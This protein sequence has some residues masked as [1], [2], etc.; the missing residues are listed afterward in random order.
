MIVGPALP[1]LA[2]LALAV[3]WLRTFC[4]AMAV[5]ALPYVVAIPES[6]MFARLVLS[7]AYWLHG[8]A[9]LHYTSDVLAAGPVDEGCAVCYAPHGLIPWGFTLNGAVR[10]KTK[11]VHSQPSSFR[12]GSRVSGVQAPVLFHIPILNVYLKLLGCCTPATKAGMTELMRARLTFGIIPGGSEEVAHH[13][14]GRDVVYILQRAGFIKY[15][16]QHGYRLVLAF[17]FGDCDLFDSVQLVR[18]LNLALVR[19]FGFV[20]PLFAGWRWMPLLPRP[21]VALDTVVGASIQLP[22][23]ANPSA[24]EVAHWHAV[25]VSELRR[26]YDSYKAQFGY[27]DRALVL[28]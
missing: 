17:N 21:D 9:T 22:R 10:A 11:L 6:A 4:A 26:V 19:Q 23:I 25:Y 8:G 16:L 24:E 3:G 27:G 5:I 1:L 28:R 20:L 2:A 7:S 13:Q 15:C 12:V 18:P 14:S